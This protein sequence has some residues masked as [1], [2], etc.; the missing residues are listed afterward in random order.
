MK[1]APTDLTKLAAR[2]NGKFP[3]VQVARVIEGSDEVAAHGSRDMP[4]WGEVFQKMN[5]ATA[6]MRT[7]N[8]TE[9]LQSI[10]GK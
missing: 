1:S 2:N 6:K 3:D 4:V 5:A 7:A 10:Q 8:L 9:Y